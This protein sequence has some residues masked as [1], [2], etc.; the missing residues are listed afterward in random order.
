V[1]RASSASFSTRAAASRADRSAARVSA[2]QAGT[3]GSAVSEFCLCCERW[4]CTNEVIQY[5]TTSSSSSSS[6]SSVWPWVLGR[7]CRQGGGGG[8]AARLA[9][10]VARPLQLPS[11]ARQL[12]ELRLGR[13]AALRQLGVHV[14]LACTERQIRLMTNKQSQIAERKT[15]DGRGPGDHTCISISLITFT[16]S[17]KVTFG[18]PVNVQHSGPSA[19]HV[20][21]ARGREEGA[22][23]RGRERERLPR[24][25]AR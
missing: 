3:R 11:R 24:A 12:L 20:G 8:G 19:A 5:N 4:S 14:R 21:T 2:C 17:L 18:Y 10:R 7:G 9:E 22:W 13:R 15:G 16:N 25:S 23:E 6:S 1:E